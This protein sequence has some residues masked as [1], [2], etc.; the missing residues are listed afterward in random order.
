MIIYVF[1]NV[2]FSWSSFFFFCFSE[3]FQII[4]WR[5]ID[6]NQ[7]WIF[8]NF[9]C[10]AFCSSIHFIDRPYSCVVCVNDTK[11]FCENSILFVDFFYLQHTHY[12]WVLFIIF[13]IYI[14]IL[15]GNWRSSFF[16]LLFFSCC[17]SWMLVFHREMSKI[18]NKIASIIVCLMITMFVFLMLLLYMASFA[19]R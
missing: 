4:H 2:V 9:V 7:M 3:R 15:W 8:V 5:V 19:Q 17:R 6:V 1:S 18:P 13:R 16:E 11:E 10:V 12:A 14:C